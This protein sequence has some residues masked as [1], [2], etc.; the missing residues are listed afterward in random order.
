MP[1]TPWMSTRGF[2][3]LLYCDCET[4]ER[5]RSLH[6]KG[7]TP[8]Q[9]QQ[10]VKK[11]TCLKCKDTGVVPTV[12]CACPLGNA[13]ATI[14]L[15]GQQDAPQLPEVSCKV[16]CGSGVVAG[17]REIWVEEWEESDSSQ[18]IF[19][20]TRRVVRRKVLAPVSPVD[21]STPLGIARLDVSE[22]ELRHLVNR[23]DGTLDLETASIARDLARDLEQELPQATLEIVWGRSAFKTAFSLLKEGRLVPPSTAKE[24]YA[25]IKNARWVLN[26]AALHWG[27][28]FAVRPE[29]WGDDPRV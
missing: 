15:R 13:R 23:E 5:A 17:G 19:A 8:V 25:M 29:D 26:Y 14:D 3:Q 20:K 11:S 12:Y 7:W 21:S 1:W 27:L 2:G 24:R 10:G 22:R 18:P 6:E 4:G 16:C 9:G 28:G